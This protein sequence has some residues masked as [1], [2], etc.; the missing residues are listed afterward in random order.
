M[1][2]FTFLIMDNKKNGWQRLLMFTLPYFLFV[3]FFQVIGSLVVGISPK[4][5]NSAS[6]LQ[7]LIISLFN[8]LGTFLLLRF[9][10]K[11]F[12]KEKFI[13]LGFKIKNR[14]KDFLIGF[15]IGLLIMSLSYI[16]LINLKEIIFND[17][18]IDFRE[19]IISFFLFL[20][21]AVVE[22]MLFRGYILRNLMISFNKHI[23]L[24]IS[25]ILFT[26]AHSPNLEMS[27]FSFF[28]IFLAGILLGISYIHTKNLW[29]PIALHFS[30]NL[31]QSLFGFNVSGRDTY[32]IIEFSIKE[33]NNI[34]GG[35]FGFEGSVLAIGFCIRF[36][37]FNQL[38]ECLI[39]KYQKNIIFITTDY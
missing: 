12:D 5:I 18:V 38:Y 10:M 16:L 33:N 1:S 24:L 34:N 35:N 9:F 39:Y 2:Y 32:S 19:I 36:V 11:S 30:W 3:G 37:T 15:F 13:N 6:S 27:F 25:A 14:L 4:E 26:L 31:F 22:E 21:I 23:A 17:L 7:L 8:L 28:N 20:I 29:F